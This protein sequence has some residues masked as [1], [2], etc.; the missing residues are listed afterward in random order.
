MPD[1]FSGRQ[2]EQEIVLQGH[3]DIHGHEYLLR[4]DPNPAGSGWVARVE[5]YTTLRGATAVRRQISDEGGPL[6]T[7]ADVS[8]AMTAEG[9]TEEEALN[10]LEEEIRR[11]VTEASRA[12]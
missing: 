3:I 2:A 11:A 1:A 4:A 12:A 8:R 5:K 7:L 10:A 6:G 9:A